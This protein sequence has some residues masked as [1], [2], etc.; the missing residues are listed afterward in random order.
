MDPEHLSM[1]EGAAEKS[2]PDLA[3]IAAKTVFAR[4]RANGN[5]RV[6][7][8]RRGPQSSRSLEQL[9][10]SLGERAWDTQNFWPPI[11]ADEPDHGRDLMDR[12]HEAI[13]LDCPTIV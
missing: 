5:Q 12:I 2:K 6:R 7:P 8:H 3:L 10:P 11:N 13:E 9:G 1:A 4:A